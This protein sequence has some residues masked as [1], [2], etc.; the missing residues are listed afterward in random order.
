MS[1][2]ISP[3]VAASE[4]AAA[5]E[6]ASLMRKV[7]WRLMPLIMLCYFF[8]FFDRIN[9]GFAKAQLQ[10]DL[11]IS[12][13]AYGLG[14]SLFV[15][16]YVAMGVPSNMMLY[17]FG[18]RRWI[19]AIMVFWGLATAAMVLVQGT[20]SFYA[21]R[22]L[23]GAMEAGFAPGVLYYLTLWFPP[24]HR[25]RATALLFLASALSGA[26]GGPLAGLVLTVMDHTAGLAGW[27]W[28]FLCGGAPSV[29][30][31]LVVLRRLDDGVADAAWL[32]AEERARLSLGVA[33]PPAARTGHSLVSAVRTPGFLLLGLA[34]FV[35]QVGSYGLNFWGPDLIRTASGGSSLL[36]GLLTAAPYVC[37]AAAMIWLGRRADASGRRDRYVIGCLIAGAAGFWAAGAFAHDA[38]AVVLALALIGAGVLA[39]IPAF[40]ALPPRLMTGVGAA[41]GIALINTVGQLG[42]IVSPLLVGRVK[43]ATGS[44][45]PALYLI[46]ALSVACAVMLRVAAP[47]ALRAS[48]R[49]VRS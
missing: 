31:G 29:L 22:L 27:R 25:G 41:G 9:I 26:I 17:R 40:W 37:G 24:A 2:A 7:A 43:D 3:F 19:A 44:T 33:G 42:G 16:G 13:T 12:N 15:I 48:D 21:L 8:A 14:A 4:P 5:R 11:H 38:V 47:A 32:T 46:A 30:L 18:A 20:A 34:Y 39:A 23:I 6:S 36:V 49:A 35:I 10:A 28:L 1:E 45:T